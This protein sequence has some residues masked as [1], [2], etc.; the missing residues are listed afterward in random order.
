MESKTFLVTNVSP[1]EG[2]DDTPAGELKQRSE[3][4]S[5]VADGDPAVRLELYIDD[6]AR[7]GSYAVGTRFAIVDVEE[8]LDELEPE[9]AANPQPAAAEPVAAAATAAITTEGQP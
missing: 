7:F 5:A 6:A 8:E 2:R 1:I 4:I 9:P 3:L